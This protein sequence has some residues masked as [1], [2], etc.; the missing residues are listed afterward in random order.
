METY[1]LR[2]FLYSF[3]R[4]KLFID[5]KNPTCIN[6]WKLLFLGIRFL[7]TNWYLE[8]WG[9]TENYSWHF[10]T[11]K[12]MVCLMIGGYRGLWTLA[13]PE[14]ALLTLVPI[15]PRS[16]DYLTHQSPL[17]HVATGE[18][19]Y[20][21]VIF[22]MVELLLQSGCSKFCARY[23]LLCSASIKTLTSIL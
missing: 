15:F 12:R 17:K 8:L 11:T 23:F 22:C 6:A 10:Y 2:F 13:I 14:S 5:L 19:Y 4:K 1:S 3:V 21:A 18:Q 9:G 7:K 20:L 16:S